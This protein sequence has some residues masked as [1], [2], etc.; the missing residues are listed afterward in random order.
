[1][2]RIQI[3]AIL[4]TLL[5]FGVLT[6]LEDSS[7]LAAER[8]RLAVF[9]LELFDYSHEGELNGVRADETE[10]LIITS[11]ELRAAL[12]KTGQF[13]L[14]DLSSFD[15]EI[16]ASRPLRTCQGCDVR[17]AQRAG[18]ELLLMGFVYKVSN[19]ILDITLY[20]RDARTGQVLQEAKTSIR[21]NTDETWRHGVR[22]LVRN[23]IASKQP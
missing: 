3:F 6:F 4:T 14:V 8:K 20:L 12:E 17:M 21:G 15:E 23:R 7:T 19:L 18:A 5:A 2:S 1:M 16:A 13:D 9:D 22:W 11:N 10:R